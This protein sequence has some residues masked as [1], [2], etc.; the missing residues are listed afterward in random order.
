MSRLFPLQAP[1][2]LHD[3]LDLRW[4]MAFQQLMIV[5][6]ELELNLY[7]HLISFSRIKRSTSLLMCLDIL[8]ILNSIRKMHLFS[9]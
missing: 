1:I 7:F 8:L 2:Q 3:L 6:K 5:V 4:M 9:N